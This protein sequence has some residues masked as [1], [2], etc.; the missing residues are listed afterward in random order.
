MHLMILL[1]FQL[2]SQFILYCSMDI[3]F[4]F[5]KVSISNFS[6]KR[7]RL[8]LLS[9]MPVSLNKLSEGTELGGADRYFLAITANI[10]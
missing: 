10:E 7:H 5:I 9:I 3:K 4:R 1:N 2:N 6:A 8:L